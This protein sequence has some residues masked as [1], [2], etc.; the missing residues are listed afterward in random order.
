MDKV[1][2][3]PLIL[4][5]AGYD[6]LDLGAPQY[7]LP[8]LR[9]PLLFILPIIAGFILWGAPWG[10]HVYAQTKATPTPTPAPPTPTY[11]LTCTP[12]P[13]PTEPPPTGSPY[14]T[15][16]Y[17]PTHTPAP[18]THTPAHTPTA[19]W[20]IDIPTA[21]I[22]GPTAA[23]PFKLATP[24]VPRLRPLSDT[25][26][27]PAAIPVQMITV[28]ATVPPTDVPTWDA[29]RVVEMS[30]RL[31]PSRDG[32]SIVKNYLLDAQ[33]NF[34]HSLDIKC[35][36]SNYSE[37]LRVN[38]PD[39]QKVQFDAGAPYYGF[40]IG[41]PGAV[42]DLQFYRYKTEKQAI[43]ISE[44]VKLPV[45]ENQIIEIY[46][47]YGATPLVDHAA[48]NPGPGVDN[49]RSAPVRQPAP[50]SGSGGTTIVRQ[51]VIVVVTATP[52]PTASLTPW[53]IYVTN[54]PNATYALPTRTALPTFPPPPTFTP[55]RGFSTPPPRSVTPFP[56]PTWT[57]LAPVSNSVTA[58]RR[59]YKIYLPVVL[60]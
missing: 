4:R 3:Q 58:A 31:D 11:T 24:N 49:G 34:T 19:R 21:A 28:T 39:S 40:Y 55:P 42:W 29:W 47:Q 25:A 18:A 20:D 46:W 17:F 36:M 13:A 37:D 52:A 35:R 9:A 59:G 7:S 51:T 27:A 60:K 41:Q 10:L 6:A 54:T 26:S 56:A 12:T 57:V 16:T 23:S 1:Y 48:V 2:G 44:L 5:P 32:S 22:G 33:G 14:P 50:A 30:T 53:I 8:P 45:N 43:E 15:Y 38:E